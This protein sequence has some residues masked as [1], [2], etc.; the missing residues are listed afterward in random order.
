MGAS[1]IETEKM[2]LPHE[3][4]S[5]VKK[6]PVDLEL[7]DLRRIQIGDVGKKEYSLEAKSWKYKHNRYREKVTWLKREW[8]RKEC[9]L[10]SI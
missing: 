9:H 2:R 1:H 4:M 6:T 3:L 10:L 5:I 7:K 8:Q